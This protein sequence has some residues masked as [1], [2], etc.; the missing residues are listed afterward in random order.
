[1]DS[2]FQLDSMS[3]SVQPG[4]A[5]H[6]LEGDA[7]M[8]AVEHSLSTDYDSFD[9]LPEFF[10]A[11][12]D[13]NGECWPRPLHMQNVMHPFSPSENTLFSSFR[14]NQWVPLE[15]LPEFIMLTSDSEGHFWEDLDIPTGMLSTEEI[16]V[17]WYFEEDWIMDVANGRDYGLI[18]S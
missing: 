10:H 4:H 1:M 3:E 15:D 5:F 12:C 2:S 18:L 14:H 9:E 17:L 11:L 16:E 8:E 7:M 13:S 6:D